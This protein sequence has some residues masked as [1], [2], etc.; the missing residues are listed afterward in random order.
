MRIVAIALVVLFA[1]VS[2]MGQVSPDEAKQKLEE[3]QKQRQAEREQIVQVTAGEL[4]DLRM[5]IKRLEGEVKSLNA[6]LGIKDAGA[7]SSASASAAPAKKYHEI[8]E[9][10]M[11]KDE[12]MM[13]IKA[14]SNLKLIGT[15][16]D[17]GVR[18]SSEEIVVARES[19]G[20][21]DAT[22]QT[23]DQ[24]PTRTRTAADA[25]GTSR[26]QVDRLRNTGKKE[27]LIIAKLGW[28]N[29]P[30]GSH[31]DGFGRTITDM[32]RVQRE[33]SRILVTFFDGVV[34]SISDERPWDGFRQRYDV[35]R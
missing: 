22:V 33:E 26:T 32:K 3:K 18:K 14:H 29:E 10:G 13:Y 24:T 16:A 23:D 15:A 25:Q 20:K 8:I 7:S 30:G 6:Q 21:R 11:T 34:G 5:E 2:A 19:S 35:A 12:V 4:A 28:V 31:K 1:G 27:T 9:V 17:S